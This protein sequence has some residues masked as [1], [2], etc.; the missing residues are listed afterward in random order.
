MRRTWWR[1][2]FTRHWLYYV[3]IIT[4]V[5]TV[6]GMVTLLRAKA[7]DDAD[8]V[9]QGAFTN[10]V[11]QLC[12]GAR[13]CHMLPIDD[14]ETTAAGYL[15]KSFK[16]TVPYSEAQPSPDGR[17]WRCAWPQPEDR[18]CFFAPPPAT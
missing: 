1:S 11:G 5:I 4:W 13:D 7:H 17:Y 15:V 3:I 18:K 6:V 16:E 2:T 9:R 14:V 12:C 8:W 10:A